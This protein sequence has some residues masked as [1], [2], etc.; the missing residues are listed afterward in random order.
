MIKVL[1]TW[2]RSRGSFAV[3]A[4]LTGLTN[5]VLV[6]VG[7]I[8]GAAAARLLGPQGRGELAAI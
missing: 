5:L 7:L 8:T 1:E 2:Q 6:A 3:N 4:V